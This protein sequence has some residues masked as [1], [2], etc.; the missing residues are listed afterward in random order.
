M[1]MTENL[2]MEAGAYK[3]FRYLTVDDIGFDMWVARPGMNTDAN[4]EM[5][6]NIDARYTNTDSTRVQYFQ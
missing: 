6:E 4:G 1:T 2:L 5:I 3:G